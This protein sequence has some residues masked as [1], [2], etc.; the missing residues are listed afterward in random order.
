MR[1][2]LAPLL[3]LIALAG[4]ARK[5]PDGFQGYLEGE[6][7]QVASPLAGRVEQLSV[8]KGDRVEA[9]APLFALERSAELAAQRQAA[10]QL[11]AA[12]SRLD[13]LRKG[14]RPS[15]MAALE[16][17]LSQA[18]AAAELSKL[19]LD[20]RKSLFES[21]VTSASDYDQARLTHERNLAA[22]EEIA[23]Q[24]ATGRLGARDDALKAAE[25]DVAAAAAALER[26]DWSVAQKVQSA[27]RAGLVYDTLY[28]TGEFAGAASPVVTLLPPEN[29]KVRFFV[30]EAEFAAVKAGT[31][32]RVTL[33]GRP[34]L[35]ARVSY[36]APRPEYTPPVLYNRA[37]RA[38]LVFMVEAVLD[39]AAARDLHPG[40]PVDV[41]LVTP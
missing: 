33:T 40:Q 3:L 26:A 9:G 11:A 23:A 16:A 1:S 37:N 36:L 35:E 2:I 31:R 27:P 38:K 19:D 17:R 4:C 5:A 10:G 7:I 30:P 29:L 25:A 21:R 8:S 13:D 15:E 20:R 24:I 22:I 6:F 41:A 12:R 34:D 32:V 39:P 14:A 18:R 28:R